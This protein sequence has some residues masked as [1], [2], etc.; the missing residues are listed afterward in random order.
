MHGGPAADAATAAGD[1][2]DTHSLGSAAI[3]TGYLKG[4]LGSELCVK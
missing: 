3:G 2:D 4:V 1:D